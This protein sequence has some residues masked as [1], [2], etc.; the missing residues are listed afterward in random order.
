MQDLSDIQKNNEKE[1][2]IKK[3]NDFL[4]SFSRNKISD[5]TQIN[6]L[7][8]ILNT[9]PR[10][11]LDEINKIVDKVNEINNDKN[12]DE[13]GKSAQL[14]ACGKALYELGEAIDDY[15]LSNNLKGFGA[16]LC[17]MGLVMAALFLPLPF[18]IFLGAACLYACFELAVSFNAS[19]S[20]QA[21]NEKTY[22]EPNPYLSTVLKEK[23][24][25]LGFF[26]KPVNMGITDSSLLAATLFKA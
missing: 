10:N 20:K 15:S 4:L 3:L 25:K 26:E 13:K 24:Y 11:V 14:F 19:L 6:G 12:Y 8:K 23:A 2:L 9:V 7:N 18:N 17:F 16:S 22:G 1:E 5:L 21:K